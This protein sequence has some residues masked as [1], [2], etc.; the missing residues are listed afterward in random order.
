M[1]PQSNLSD[2]YEIFGDSG[3]KYLVTE[4]KFMY[5]VETEDESKRKG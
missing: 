5:I 3:R 4:D 2:L 1:I